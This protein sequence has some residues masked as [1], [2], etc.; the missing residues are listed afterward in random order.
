MVEHGAA[1]H[2]RDDAGGQTDDEGEQ[3]RE[4]RQLNRGRKQDEE[5]VDNRL[6]RDDGLAEVALEH[7][8]DVDPVL[9]EQRFV[10]A[11]LRSERGMTLRV[12]SAFADQQLNRIARYQANHRESEQGDPDE[13][14][15]HEAEARED[16]TQQQRVPS[17]REGRNAPPARA[18]TVKPLTV[19]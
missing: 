16:E 15:G 5:L 9:L 8:L 4:Q 17:R 12:Q 3:Q 10:E 18:Q 19:I 1:A 11:E 2:A 14:R 13:G 6:L 7:A